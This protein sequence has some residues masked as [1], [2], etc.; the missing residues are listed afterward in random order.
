MV[1]QIARNH[2]WSWHFIVMR[3]FDMYSSFSGCNIEDENIS[4]RRTANLPS[5]KRASEQREVYLFPKKE[6][7]RFAFFDGEVLKLNIP[8][9]GSW[10][11][12]DYWNEMIKMLIRKDLGVTPCIQINPFTSTI[13]METSTA[14]Q[15]ATLMMAWM[16]A[17]SNLK[18]YLTL[19]WTVRL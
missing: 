16:L 14:W 8:F 1:I 13:I 9:Y 11:S 6:E 4:T 12:G 15:A 18:K 17:L 7:K 2:V 10:E 5:I 19:P 3:D